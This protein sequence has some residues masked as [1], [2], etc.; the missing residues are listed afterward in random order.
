MR[1]LLPARRWLPSDFTSLSSPLAPYKGDKY[2]LLEGT[3]VRLPVSFTTFPLFETLCSI[4]RNG[5]A[6]YTGSAP[7]AYFRVSPGYHTIIAF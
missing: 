6:E 3:F 2:L 1:C 7:M 4:D 5:T